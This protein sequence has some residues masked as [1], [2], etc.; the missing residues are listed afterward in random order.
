[1]RPRVIPVLL[2]DEG[3]RLVKTRCFRN[4]V[5]LGDPHNAVRI[6]NEKEVDEIIFLDICKSRNKRPPDIEYLKKLAGE[7]FMPACYGG[8]ITRLEEIETIL[9][10]GFERISINSAAITNPSIVSDIAKNFGSSTL[11]VGVDVMIDKNDKYHLY[12]H[13]TKKHTGTDLLDH[14]KRL[15][16][17]GAGEIMLNAVYLD[18]TGLGY[19]LDLINLI[20]SAVS[21]P[22]IAGGGASCPDD[23]SKAVQAGASAVAAGRQFVFW[24]KHNAVLIQYPG[25]N[26]LN[27]AFHAT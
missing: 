1:M 11:V 7:C 10:S 22:V 27:K 13:V 9:M 21:V 17:T 14:I 24:G 19:D 25:S 5:Y 15:D 16:D 26:E 2:I 12:N 8:G 23:F 6:F 20:S 4:P 3:N 18:G